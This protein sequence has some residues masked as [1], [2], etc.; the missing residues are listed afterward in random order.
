MQTIG[1]KQQ[2]QRE[3]NLTDNIILLFGEYIQYWT[4]PFLLNLLINRQFKMNFYI[5]GGEH[6]LA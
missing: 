5:D 3:D 4:T 6:V 1:Q 2:E